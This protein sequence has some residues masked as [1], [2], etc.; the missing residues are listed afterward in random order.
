MVFLGANVFFPEYTGNDRYYNYMDDCYR[1]IPRPVEDMSE[2]DRIAY[3]EKNQECREKS[4]AEQKKWDE[5]K[6]AY[7][8]NKYVV[9]TIF[10]L[11]ILLIALFIPLL[12]DSV[13]MGLF[14]GS[15]AATFGATIRYFDT[16]S[17]IGFLVVV[18][19]FF[20]MLFFINKKKDSFMDWKTKARAV[21]VKRRVK[22]RRR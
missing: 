10:N 13:I 5:E 21:A 19:T 7:E 9:V 1:A 8:G 17:K 22:R 15:I 3:D 14:L 11:I 2:E 18:I 6:N 20:V 4:L 16:N 12:Q